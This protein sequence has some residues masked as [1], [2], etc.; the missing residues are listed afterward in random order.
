M[1]KSPCL[2]NSLIT[3]GVCPST[4]LSQKSEIWFLDEN[5]R[6]DSFETTPR[7]VDAK[8]V[9]I[10]VP[11]ALQQKTVQVLVQ[12]YNSYIKG[13]LVSPIEKATSSTQ[14]SKP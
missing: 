1:L 2:V 13:T 9:Y 6:L 7:F 12:P 5:S 14:V 11:E 10:D 3:Y 8:Y 4:A